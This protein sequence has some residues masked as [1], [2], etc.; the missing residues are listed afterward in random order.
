MNITVELIYGFDIGFQIFPIEEEDQDELQA[1]TVIFL[2]LGIV[3]L[4]FYFGK[5]A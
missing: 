1:T 2:N 5:P 4:G 3:C